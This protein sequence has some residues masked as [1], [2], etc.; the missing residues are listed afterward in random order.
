MLTALTR[1]VSSTIDQCQLT[2]MHREAIDYGKACEQHRKYQ[3]CI[4]SM[5]LQVVSLPADPDYPDAVFVEDTAV[6]LEE[7][8][9]IGIPACHSRRGEV[10]SVASELNKYRPVH[11]LKAPATLEGGDVVRHGKRLFVGSSRR[12]NSEGILQL[13][14]IVEPYGYHVIPVHVSGCLHL[15]TGLS[16]VG[17]N[18]ILVN[19]RW[20]DTAPFKDFQIIRVE[21]PWAANTLRINGA[22]LMPEKFLLTRRQLE[23]HGLSVHTVEISELLKAEA[24]VTCMSVIFESEMKNEKQEATME[25]QCHNKPA[26]FAKAFRSAKA[27]M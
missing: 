6:V 16:C 10:S 2:F 23:D 13:R 25:N 26:E 17:E 5:G 8:A 19:D 22:V 9:I 20:V 12:T 7:V 15:S 11:F 1:G 24:G 3:D 18:L 14:D 4:R 27:S 21:E